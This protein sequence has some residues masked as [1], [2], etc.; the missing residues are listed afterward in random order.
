MRVFGIFSSGQMKQRLDLDF[1]TADE[2]A[3]ALGQQMEL[4]WWFFK[5]DD[6]ITVQHLLHDVLLN[7]DFLFCF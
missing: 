4:W 5:V 6:F 3:A 1:I 7:L 2:L